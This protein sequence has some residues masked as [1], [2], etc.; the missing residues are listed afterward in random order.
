MNVTIPFL[1]PD[2]ISR[3]EAAA[4]AT[5]RDLL[6]GRRILPVEG[7]F[8]P[9]FTTFELGNDD[10]RHHDNF[11]DAITV[12]S[13]PLSVPMIFRRFVLS[14]RQ[15]AAHLEHGQPLDLTPVRNATMAVTLRE[16]ELVYRGAPELGQAGLATAEGRNHLEGGDWE[17]VEQVLK[18]V[19]AAVTLLDEQGYRGPYALVLAPRLY[20]S[21]FRRYPDGSDLVQIEHLKSLC[22]AGIYKTQIEGALLLTP[23]AG[24]L[25]I[26]EDLHVDYTIPDPTHFNFAIKES[27]VL[28]IDA[29][30]AICTI[31]PAGMAAPKEQDDSE[32]GRHPS[33]S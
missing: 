19:L 6:T 12:V 14:R 15:V 23:E 33:R 21:L 25:L 26:G 7:P 4:V 22:T 8:G 18:D 29:P 20:N 11:H 3:M 30:G 31:A 17:S 1:D 27:L 13:R 32:V 5:A 28:K 9:G 10:L 24:T 16:E 2:L